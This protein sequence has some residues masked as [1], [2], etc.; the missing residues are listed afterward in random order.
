MLD[1]SLFYLIAQSKKT[2]YMES[3]RQ[4]IKKLSKLFN[5]QMLGISS[6]KKWVKME[7]ILMLEMQEDNFL[8][9]R[10]KELQLLDPS[11]N[12]QK[13]SCLMKP[14]VLQIKR[15]KERFKQQLIKL[16]KSQVQL[17][18]L[19]L[20]TDSQQ[21]KILIKS[22]LCKKEKLLKKEIILLS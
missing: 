11:L 6:M 7:L 13:Y 3:Q 14:L 19:L 18:Q 10:N 21:L 1:K 15:M 22:S 8:E 9:V 12:I 4:Q 2:F 5:Q 16:D 20:L 17:Q